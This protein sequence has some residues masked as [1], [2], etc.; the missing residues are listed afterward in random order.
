MA[1]RLPP[2]IVHRTRRGEQL[3]DWLDV[4]T[5]A[6][7]ELA[8]ELEELEEHRRRGELIDAARLRRLIDRWPDRTAARRSGSGARLPAGAPTR[9]ARQPLP[10]LV[11]TARRG[12]AV[13]GQPVTDELLGVRIEL[14]APGFEVEKPVV[15]RPLPAGL[16][17]LVAER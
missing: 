13:D 6:R 2:E 8:R 9:A 4:M 15:D 5:A 1:D 11:R 16:G 3:P 7:P 17:H 14:A 12:C 10:A